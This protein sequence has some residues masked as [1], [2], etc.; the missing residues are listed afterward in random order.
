MK[1][2]TWD[3]YFDNI[4]QEVSKRSPDTRT[5]V[6]CVMVGPDKEIRITG[7]NGLVEGIKETP[8]KISGD[9][10]YYFI[11]HAEENSISMAAK[12]GISLDKCVCY[13]GW[14]PCHRCMRQMLRV[15]IREFVIND[16]KINDRWKESC[17]YSLYMLLEKKG[18]IRMVDSNQ[19]E[20]PFMFKKCHEFLEKKNGN[21]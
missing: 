3:Q 19:N 14:C 5:K 9:S 7:Y 13:I 17:Y 6:G 1:K 15:G 11:V 16:R 20:A 10:K 2:P 21:S 18:I 8:E 4:R 12:L